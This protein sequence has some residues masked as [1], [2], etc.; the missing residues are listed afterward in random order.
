[1][2]YAYKEFMSW[3]KFVYKPRGNILTEDAAITVSDSFKTRHDPQCKV[4]MKEEIKISLSLLLISLLIIPPPPLTI[5]I[6]QYI[7]HNGYNVMMTMR[8]GISW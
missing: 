4:Q 3:Y 6:Y 2:Y 8:S 1:M 5:M 7:L